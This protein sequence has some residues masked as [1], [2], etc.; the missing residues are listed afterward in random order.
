MSEFV[1]RKQKLPQHSRGDYRQEHVF[2]LAQELALY[3]SYQQQIAACDAQIENYLNQLPTQVS[4]EQLG[5]PA[6]SRKRQQN[7]PSFDLRHHLYC[8]SG[9]DFTVVDG[10][11]VL[12]VQTIRSEV[13][14]DPTRFPTAKQFVVMPGGSVGLL[15]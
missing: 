9:V 12:T 14:L 6:V 1:N 2:V 7:Q 10:M 4:L 11:G 8:I 15:D 13:G 3:E 5:Q